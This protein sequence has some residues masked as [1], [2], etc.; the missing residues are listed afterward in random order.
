MSNGMVFDS[1]IQHSSHL[2][3]CAEMGGKLCF[4]LTPTLRDDATHWKDAAEIHYHPLRCIMV[5]KKAASNARGNE[6][7]PIQSLRFNWNL[8]AVAIHQ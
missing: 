7:A 8:L 4:G 6:M 2:N 5:L 3:V 1:T